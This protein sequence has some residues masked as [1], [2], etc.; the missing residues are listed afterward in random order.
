MKMTRYMLLPLVLVAFAGCTK[1]ERVDA[2][3]TKV[4]FTV[5]SYAAQTK[6]E[7]GSGNSLIDAENVTQF[8]AMAYMHGAGVDGF[9]YYFGTTGETI[10]YDEETKTWAP[11]LD[12]YW[13]SAPESYIDFICW[14]DKLAGSK[15]TVSYSA[16]NG[17]YSAS[18]TWTDREIDADD[19]I[20]FADMAWRQKDNNT[21]QSQTWYHNDDVTEGVPTLFRHALAK[22]VFKAFATQL[23]DTNPTTT[24]GVTI[25]SLEISNVANM[26]TLVLTN[27]DPKDDASS[28]TIPSTKAWS[29]DGWDVDASSLEDLTATQTGSGSIKVMDLELEPEETDPDAG[30]IPGLSSVT[31]LPQEIGSD[32]V[33]TINY[34]ISITY[35]TSGTPYSVENRSATVPMYLAEGTAFSNDIDE[36]EMNKK[37]TYTIKINPA[38]N[39]IL[40]LPDTSDWTEVTGTLP[41]E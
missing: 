36:W 32:M 20:L 17:K 8:Q 24:Y 11:A 2:P 23:E 9:K 29:T 16:T 27:S 4:T 18:M 39:V 14:Y 30:L 25:T 22:L 10:S 6:A 37:Y 5:G 3:A 34:N 26:G 41:I 40:F 38:T 19:N 28:V 15:P 33:L 31:V 1:V 12:Y 13:P 21:D 35:G 7:Q